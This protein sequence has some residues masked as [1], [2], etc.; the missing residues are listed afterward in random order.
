[1]R[2]LRGALG[3]SDPQLPENANKPILSVTTFQL[4]IAID[5][6][7]AESGSTPSTS[8]AP[9]TNVLTRVSIIF[10]IRESAASPCLS[11]LRS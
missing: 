3:A 2:S 10:C 6:V 9:A 8:R 7:R 5:A 4:A 1:M 11:H